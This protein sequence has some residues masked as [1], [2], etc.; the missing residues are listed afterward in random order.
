M[1]AV[2]PYYHTKPLYYL[3]HL[4][5]HEGEG[6]LLSWLKSQ[7]LAEGLSAG[8]F[9]SDQQEAIFSI[10]VQLTPEGRQHYQ[11]IIDATFAYIDLMKNFAD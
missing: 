1:P 11:Q 7:N 6:S 8:L 9:S 5:G 2:E 3:S 4:L 10:S